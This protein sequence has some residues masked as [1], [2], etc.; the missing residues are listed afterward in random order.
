MTKSHFF[1]RQKGRKER[2]C[3]RRDF[4]Q[5]SITDMRIRS[6]STAAHICCPCRSVRFGTGTLPI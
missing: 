1:S 6:Q 2:L 4:I 3:L 5:S